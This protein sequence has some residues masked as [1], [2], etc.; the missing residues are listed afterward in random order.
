MP[1]GAVHPNK[2]L[3]FA[4]IF[5]I[6]MSALFDSREVGLAAPSSGRSLLLAWLSGL[7]AV[8][9][10]LLAVWSGLPS[11]ALASSLLVSTALAAASQELMF[12]GI[13]FAGLRSRYSVLKTTWISSIL[14]G[15]AWL[16]VWIWY[17]A[18]EHGISDMMLGFLMSI[19]FSAIRVRTGSLYP[20]ILLHAVWSYC[21]T[22]LRVSGEGVFWSQMLFI[23]VV[24]P[25]PI[26][27]LFLL[28]KKALVGMPAVAAG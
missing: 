22:L 7:Y 8:C 19:L 12:R 15:I 24:I 20:C 23:A 25:L 11:I 16:P 10:L 9:F 21:L 13:L 14:A 27:G 17:G 26:Y 5:L 28:R 1:L 18:W 2:A 6:S 4:V 3:L